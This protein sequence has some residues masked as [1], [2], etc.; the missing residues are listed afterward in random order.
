MNSI[1]FLSSNPKIV[2]SGVLHIKPGSL[3]SNSQPCQHEKNVFMELTV[4]VDDLIND[5]Y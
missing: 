4:A 1:V 5:N 3:S 2:S